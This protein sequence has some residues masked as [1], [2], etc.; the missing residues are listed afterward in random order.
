VIITPEDLGTCT[1]C[2]DL[3]SSQAADGSF[4]C[5]RCTPDARQRH[6]RT[7][8]I[9]ELKRKIENRKTWQKK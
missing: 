7:M 5:R 6:E 1:K 4:F 3:H 2:N 9:L 8:R